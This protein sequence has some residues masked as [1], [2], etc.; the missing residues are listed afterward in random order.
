MFCKPG[1]RASVRYSNCNWSRLLIRE[2]E[3][4]AWNLHSRK[5]K[6]KHCMVCGRHSKVMFSECEHEWT[7][8]QYHHTI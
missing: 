6:P 8:K 7:W 4:H 2:M 1:G 3:I 5:A